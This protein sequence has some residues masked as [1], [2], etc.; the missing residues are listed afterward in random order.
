MK[1]RKSRR[2]KKKMQVNTRNINIK[3]K[4]NSIRI[5]EGRRSRRMSHTIGEVKYTQLVS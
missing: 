1:M 4:R 3:N 5:L 2:K